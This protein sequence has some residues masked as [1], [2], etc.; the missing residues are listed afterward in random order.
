MA[1]IPVTDCRYGELHDRVCGLMSGVRS[2]Q[3]ANHGGRH[4]V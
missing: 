2:E 4:A 3:L 1:G